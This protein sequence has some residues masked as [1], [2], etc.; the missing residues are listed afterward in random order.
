LGENE[1]LLQLLNEILVR[2]LKSNAKTRRSKTGYDKP[3]FSEFQADCNAVERTLEMVQ[4]LLKITK[5]T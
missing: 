3:A 5:E 1:D 2:E 4:N